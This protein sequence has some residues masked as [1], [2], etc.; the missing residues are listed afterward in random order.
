MKPVFLITLVAGS[1][2]GALPA[3]A[4]TTLYLDKGA[5]I[6]ATSS[7]LLDDFESFAP[8]DV[9]LP[10]VTSAGVTYASLGPAFNVVVASPGYVNFGAGVSQPTTTSILTTS[11]DENFEGVF[12]APPTVL[13][14]DV[15]LNGL[16]PATIE[17]Y[18]GANL[19]DTTTWSTGDSKVFVGITSTDPITRFHFY[20][21]LGGILNTGIDNIL[22]NSVGVPDG[23]SSLLLGVFPGVLLLRRKLRDG[24]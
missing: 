8:K 22:V 1:I 17:F 7:S 18:S 20:S 15:Y 14:F 23:G 24:S 21:T 10:S 12:S 13:G 11:G 6:A 9:N 16:G 19:I 4:V 3:K 5:F 2:I